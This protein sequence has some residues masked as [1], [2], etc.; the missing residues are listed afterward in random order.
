MIGFSLTERPGGYRVRFVGPDGG[1]VERATGC[2]KKGDARNAAKGIIESEYAP[3]VVT[4]PT[5]TWEQALG[6]LNRTPDLRPDSIRSYGN[7]VAAFRKLFP[8]LSGPEAVTP[9]VALAFKREF[10]SGTYARGRASDAARYSRSPTSCRTYLR[11]LRSLWAKHFRPLG[12]AA[13]NPWLDVPYPNAPKG[14]RVRVPEEATVVA[15]FQWLANRHPGWDLPRLFVQVK[16][17]AGC[18]TLDLCKARSFDLGA[19][20]LTLRADSTKT[21]EARTIPLPAEV[22]SEL[23]RLAG[24]VW[25]WERAAV[26]CSQHRPVR[27]RESATAYSPSTWRWTVQNLFREFNEGR[28][29]GSRLRPHDLRARAITVVA[30]ATQSVDATAQALGLNAQTARHYLDAA[31]A[32]DRADIL[33]KASGLLLPPKGGDGAAEK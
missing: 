12:H 15:F 25:L 8:D 19:D 26:E 3:K 11:A 2:I 5:S 29:Q 7:A 28:P 32:F 13:G 14:K 10:L 24:P 18:R 9:A 31:K 16:M 30:A 21:R 27:G 4:T 6:D 22:A 1:R 33:R 17:L 20:S 23:R